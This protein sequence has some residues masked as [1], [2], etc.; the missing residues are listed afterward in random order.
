MR[1]AWD[2]GEGNHLCLKV[3]LKSSTYFF[4]I[5]QNKSCK[6][7]GGGGEPSFVGNESDSH[8]MCFSEPRGLFYILWHEDTKRKPLSKIPGGAAHSAG[9]EL[10]VASLPEPET[11]VPEQMS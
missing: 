11:L 1:G 9:L 7:W 4:F 10:S 2:E 3:I 5:F 8:K 6:R